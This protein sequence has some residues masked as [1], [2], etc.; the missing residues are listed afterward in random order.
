MDN[1]NE[2]I[3]NLLVTIANW[4]PRLF[5]ALLVLLIGYLIAKAIE[6][7]VKSALRG[8][9]FD[10]L[11]HRGTAGSYIA[12]VV[13][14]PTNLV[15]SVV[16]WLLW[17]G[18]LSIAVTVLGISA[19]NSFVYAIYAYVPN[20]LAALLIFIVAGAVA[21]GAAALATRL[22]GETPTGKLVAT[23]IPVLTMLIATFMILN[24]LEIA[25]AIVTITYAA[26]MGAVAL[27]MA[28]AFGLG[29][30]DVAGRLLEQ[31]YDAGR[32]NAGAVKHDMEVGKQHAV[33][34]AHK[35]MPPNP[36]SR[37]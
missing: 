20:I 10:N 28:L 1:I 29:G 19:L 26:L 30:Q 21:T 23:I 9:K 4:L 25:P 5:G 3:R 35:N 11:L 34:E 7:L 37:S 33:A 27:G 12:K 8:L 24:E 14:S 32:R 6:R 16:F 22:M 18:T 2:S 13:E 15:G 31:A 17:L 36:L